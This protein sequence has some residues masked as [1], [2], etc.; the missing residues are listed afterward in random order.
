YQNWRDDAITK[1]ESL[2]DEQKDVCIL[3]LDIKDYYHSININF[4]SLKENIEINIHKYFKHKNLNDYKDKNLK[5]S[6]KLT[7]I[8]LKIHEDYLKK[9]LIVKQDNKN[10]IENR[11]PLPIGLLSSCFLGNYFLK[12]F[13]QMVVENINPAFYGRYV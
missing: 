4:E 8:L 3:S 5:I 9:L 2:L 6:L 12:E 1:A 13:D 7:D 10:R 11:Y